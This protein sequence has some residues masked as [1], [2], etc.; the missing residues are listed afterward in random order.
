MQF[1]IVRDILDG[2]LFQ[3]PVPKTQNSEVRANS[4]IQF[5]PSNEDNTVHTAIVSF[6]LMLEG[7]EKPYAQAGWR[8]LFKT[9]EAFD[10]KTSQQNPFFAQLLVI[11]GSKLIAVLNNLCLHANMPMVP[12]SADHLVAQIKGN[13]AATKPPAEQN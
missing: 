6:A 2:V 10:P 12:F 5:L 3:H 8:F 11:G 1:S 13:A 4:G 7:N 9:D